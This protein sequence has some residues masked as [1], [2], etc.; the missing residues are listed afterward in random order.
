M[1]VDGGRC[2]A[3]LVRTL[4]GQSV[5]IGLVKA[6][7]FLCVV[8]QWPS[9]PIDPWMGGSLRVTKLA[10]GLLFFLPFPLPCGSH[11]ITLHYSTLL[12]GSLSLLYSTLLY[13]GAVFS[14][15]YITL[16]Y[17]GHYSLLYSTCVRFMV[18]GGD[19]LITPP[20]WH[21]ASVAVRALSL[22]SLWVGDVAVPLSF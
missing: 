4:P 12:G 2:R 1:A 6:S 18:A 17:W 15:L 14:L 22:P 5:P 10:G 13:S 21:P 16:H 19:L 20:L 11:Y 3:L 9:G 8:N 7:C